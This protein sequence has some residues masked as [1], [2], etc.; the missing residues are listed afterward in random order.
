VNTQA[1]PSALPAPRRPRW[2]PYLGPALLAIASLVALIFG[3]QVVVYQLS[4]IGIFAIASVGQQWVMGRTGQAS[5][6]GAAF[7][8]VGAFTTAEVATLLPWAVFPIPL[9]IGGIA[10]GVVGLLVGLTSLRLRGLYLLLSTLALQF[11]I[12]S[13]MLQTLPSVLY[14]GLPEIGGFTI[15]AGI[16]FAILVLVVLAIVCAL[17]WNLYRSPQGAAWSAIRLNEQAAA[18]QGINV[19]TW[20]LRAFIGSSVVTAVAGSLYAYLLQSVSA[21]SYTLTL[22]I[23]LISMV[24]IG[25]QYTISGPILGAALVT[26]LP[27]GLASAQGNV[28]DPVVAGWLTSNGPVVSTAIYG[29][30]LVVVLLFER[31]GLAGLL[32]RARDAV[33]RRG[34]RRAK[35][36]SA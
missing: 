33:L 4:L 9:I 30:A 22:T 35:G 26:L 5:I 32:A 24:F 14:I 3:P 12:Q 25:G 8:G 34:R 18:V 6:G 20:K 19:T 16:P 10:G 15:E 36:E 7:M 28:G 21:N 13:I 31:D 11:I 23:S 2:I 29:A 27:Y 1:V 17:L